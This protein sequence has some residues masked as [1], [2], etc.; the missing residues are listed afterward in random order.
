LTVGAAGFVMVHLPNEPRR[1]YVEVALEHLD[2][3]A[4]IGEEVRPVQLERFYIRNVFLDSD[5]HGFSGDFFRTFPLTRIESLLNDTVTS[6]E[7]FERFYESTYADL[8]IETTLSHFE[9]KPEN[10]RRARV[11][12]DAPKTPPALHYKRP[13]LEPPAGKLTDAFLLQVAMVYR[14]ARNHGEPPLK[15]LSELTET[16]KATVRYWIKQARLRGYLE[17]VEQGKVI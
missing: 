6:L 10:K 1:V 12:I 17:Q 16:S 11:K 4:L 7:I 2:A 9:N 5:L 14:D 13:T 15:H 8:N 3:S